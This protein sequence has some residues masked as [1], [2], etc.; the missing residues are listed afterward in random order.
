MQLSDPTFSRDV[1][2]A[3]IGGGVVGLACGAE[4]AC[5]GQRVLVLERGGRVGAET[6][7]RNS[8]VIHAGIYYLEGTHKALCCVEGRDLLYERCERLGIPHRRVGK[9][10]VATAP[11]EI[12]TLERMQARAVANG[13]GGIEWCDAA[14]IA[15]RE[16][17]VRAVAGLWSPNTGIVDA[18]ALVESYRAEMESAGGVVALRTEVVGLA[19]T[20]DG[21]R[22]ETIGPDG[23]TFTLDV[24]LLVNAAGLG[25]DRVAEM[26]GIDLDEQAWRL[27]FCKGSYFGAAP[28]LGPLTTHLVY[29]VPTDGGL[30]AHVTIDLDGRYRFGP[31]AEPV[32][33]IS[34]RVDPSKRDRF[35]E[36]VQRYLPEIRPEDLHP[37]MAGIR[38]KRVGPGGP[39]ADFVIEETSHLGAPGMVQL[40]GIESPGLTSAGAIARRVSEL[41]GHS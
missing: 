39:F 8:Q 26:A 2:V 27:H 33:E 40:I 4:L 10:I 14:E 36:A 20:T 41:L 31:D 30:G 5:A 29:P 37:E 12:P 21:W 23:A 34:Y 19:R 17:R 11:E 13:A 35:A 6:S 7:S 16:P 25:S 32:D 22:V 38:P 3:I 28:G 1:D 24:P 15:R 9:L 18:H